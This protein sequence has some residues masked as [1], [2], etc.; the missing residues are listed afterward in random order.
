MCSQQNGFVVELG[1][2]RLVASL[3]PLL[4][5]AACLVLFEIETLGKFKLRE[6]VQG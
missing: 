1:S 3:L 6:C 5:G 2:G 4:C